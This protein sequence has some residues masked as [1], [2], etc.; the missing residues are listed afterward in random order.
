MSVTLPLGERFSVPNNLYVI[1]TMNSA[2]KS[3]SLI[4]TA[5]R[6]RFVFI[7]MAPNE[8]LIGDS[9]LR[10]VLLALNVYVFN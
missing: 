6:R 4:D 3:I 7:E 8:S 1:G 5:L 10:N 2:D 9:S